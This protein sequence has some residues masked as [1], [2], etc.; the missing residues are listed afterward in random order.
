VNE[1]ERRRA[2]KAL[3][4]VAHGDEALWPRI[5][6]FRYRLYAVLPGCSPEV[7]AAAPDM[8]GIGVAILTLHEDEKQAGG[9]LADRGRIGVLDTAPAPGRASGEWIVLPWD[10]GI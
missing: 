10:R 3:E 6:E 8:E 1:V 4:P 2:K 7:L 9:C 5:P